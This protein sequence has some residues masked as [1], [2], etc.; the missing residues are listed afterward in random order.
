MSICPEE[1]SD[2]CGISIFKKEKMLALVK[3]KV[4]VSV[5][6]EVKLDQDEKDLLCLPPK[7]AI[8]RRLKSIDMQILTFKH[9]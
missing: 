3:E 9:N 5:I 2:Y 7:F 4:E 6:G 1:L 8:R